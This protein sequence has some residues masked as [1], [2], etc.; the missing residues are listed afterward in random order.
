MCSRQWSCFLL[1]CFKSSKWTSPEALKLETVRCGLSQQSS[2]SVALQ[3]SQPV[4]RWRAS[5]L[6]FRFVPGKLS[7]QTDCCWPWNPLRKQVDEVRSGLPVNLWKALDIFSQQSSV[8]WPL[9]VV[10]QCVQSSPVQSRHAV[11]FKSFVVPKTICCKFPTRQ[12][13]NK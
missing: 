6:M 2:V 12:L 11:L 3:I 10:H 4:Q 13:G 5:H 8:Q 9:F 1:L 7:S